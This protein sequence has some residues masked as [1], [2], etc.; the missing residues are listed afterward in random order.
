MESYL[1]LFQ[2]CFEIRVAVDVDL[3]DHIEESWVL[4][5]SLDTGLEPKKNELLD[6]TLWT[7]SSIGKLPVRPVSE[8]LMVDSLQSMSSKPRQVN[9]R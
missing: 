5:T 9:H 4:T 8:A 2:E 7:G 3:C 6:S 1:V